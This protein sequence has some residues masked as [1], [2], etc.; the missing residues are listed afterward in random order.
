MAVK[1]KSVSGEGRFGYVPTEFETFDTP[2]PVAV[3]EAPPGKGCAV[4]NSVTPS[5]VVM[6]ENPR[7]ST[8]V[9]TA[10]RANS[11]DRPCALGICLMIL[12]SNTQISNCK[13]EEKG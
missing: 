2:G 5:S 8:E 3:A 4:L 12:A 11:P 7:L 13:H 9:A 10:S 6:S 1:L